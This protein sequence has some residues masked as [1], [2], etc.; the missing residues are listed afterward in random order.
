M[1]ELIEYV[2]QHSERGAC[3]CGKCCDA[4]ENPESKQPTGHT[5][6]L[7]FFEVSAINGPDADVLRDRYAAVLEMKG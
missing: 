4:P 1:Q 2:R 7:E 6:N 5:A 3:C